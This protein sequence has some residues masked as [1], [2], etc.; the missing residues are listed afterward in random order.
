MTVIVK[1][2]V[3]VTPLRMLYEPSEV[4]SSKS[5]AGGAETTHVP[6]CCHPVDTP[7][8]SRAYRYSFVFPENDAALKVTFNVKPSC[9]PALVG[10]GEEFVP[11]IVH[12]EL[13][14]L[15]ELD[16]ANPPSHVVLALSAR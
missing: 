12:W 10:L 16:G 1:V 14:M 15:P 9:V 4:V 2:G 13:P 11:A 6:I 5:G 7:E 8:P 3:T